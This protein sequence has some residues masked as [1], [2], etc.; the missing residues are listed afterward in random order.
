M[1]QP[2][3]RQH[4]P[5][6]SCVPCVRLFAERVLVTRLEGLSCKVDEAFVPL[7]EL[8]FDYGGTRVRAN[9][10]RMRIFRSAAGGHVEALPTG[11][12][13]PSARRVRSSSGSEPSSWRA[14]SRS[15]PPDGCEADYV[16]RADGD[17]HAFCAFT[18][19]ALANWRA[20]GWRVDVDA[21][22][23]FRVVEREPTWYARVEPSDERPDWFGLELGVELD[24]RASTSWPCCSISS[25]GLDADGGLDALATSCRA[26]WALRVSDTHHVKVPPTASAGAPARRG[27]AVSGRAPP[28]SRVPGGAR[29]GARRSSTP[30]SARGRAASP[31][32][33]ERGV[34]R[35][36]RAPASRRCARPEPPG[37]L[38]RRSAPTRPRASRSSSGFAR[39]GVGGVLADEMGLGKTLQTIAHVLRR[40]G[41]R[42]ACDAPALVVAPTSL[43]ANWSR[44]LARFAP[45][46]RVVV[47]HG[48][49]RHGPLGRGPARRTSSSPRTRCS[50][51]TRTRFAEQPVPRRASSTRRRPSRTRGSQARRAL[52]RVQASTA[53][54]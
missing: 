5:A 35:A 22:Y 14:W 27:R 34:D 41:R 54:A 1:S 16:V 24:G 23:P 32:P 28:R 50:C 9:D 21:G 37:A 30:P 25:S 29:C 31:G 20:L 11:T 15:S 8:A 3:G 10:D 26:T 4:A 45:H 18:A 53:S 40:A 17:E 42:A 47:L 36:R 13:R 7:V 46:L 38:R 43:V 48:P 51:A 2:V 33:I 12:A 49:E 39:T 6:I 19:R 44:E 52:E